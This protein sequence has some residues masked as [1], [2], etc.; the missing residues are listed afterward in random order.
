MIQGAPVSSLPAVRYYR[1]RPS[2]K[3]RSGQTHAT[4]GHITP[5]EAVQVHQDESETI[6]RAKAYDPDALSTLYERYYQG[7]YRYV[8]Y[9]VGN[10]GL[11]EDLTGDIFVKMLHG[12]Q[13]YSLQGVPFS[14]WLYR[15]AR[16]RVIDHMR[17]QPEKAELSLEEARVETIASGETTLE[18]TVQRDEL[19]Q[20]V[21][22]LTGDQRQVIILKFIEDLD[23]ATIASIMGKTEGAVKSL[24]HRALDTLRQ[25]IQKTR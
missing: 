25:H 18:Q 22:V 6:Q 8:Y 23:N 16:N 2:V 11:A 4:S 19:L 12:I 20:A 15:I 9:R 3:G 14:A 1:W 5:G 24:Q 17:R 13:S 7:I 21:Q 10:A